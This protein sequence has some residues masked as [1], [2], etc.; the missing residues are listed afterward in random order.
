MSESEGERHGRGRERRPDRKEREGKGR[1]G[2]YLKWHRMASM[3][4]GRAKR[5]EG[6]GKG[7]GGGE[8]GEGNGWMDE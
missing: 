3:G 5:G 4:Y 8:S 6:R 1:E 2:K 7:E